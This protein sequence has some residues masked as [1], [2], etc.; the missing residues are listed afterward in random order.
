MAQPSYRHRV[1]YFRNDRQI[2]ITPDDRFALPAH[3]PSGCILEGRT[4]TMPLGEGLFDFCYAD[5]TRTQ[6]YAM[7]N[8]GGSYLLEPVS[9]PFED[10]LYAALFP[11]RS[12]KA[13]S[14]RA[15][16]KEYLNLLL[17]CC[18]ADYEP[19]VLGDLTAADRYA[20]WCKIN[21]CSP[22]TVHTEIIC[23]APT[24]ETRFSEKKEF[25]L[26]GAQ[27]TF[28]QRYELDQAE[29]KNALRQ[30]RSIQHV[31]LC[32]SLKEILRLE[33]MQLLE[34]NVQVRQCRRCRKYF[35]V[36]GNYPSL[37]CT[38][39]AEGSTQTCQQ[40]AAASTFH[41]KLKG[42]DGDNAWGVYSKYYKRYY[43]R[44][45][46]GALTAAEFK[47]WQENAARMR[48]RCLDGKMTLDEYRNWLD[49]YF[50]NP[51]I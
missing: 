46:R 40:L 18:D 45:K 15:L 21:D 12:R 19:E 51:S 8:C 27:Q 41:S 6:Q 13:A 22:E 44:I 24:N 47:Q 43:A 49:R 42:N 30:I 16:Q 10:T 1:V 34:E 39:T 4:I 2:Q 31:H 17:F 14:L 48:D 35:L 29:M 50:Q 36:K 23:T 3:L 9:V 26:N 33:F 38:R 20:L 7:Y 25:H 37:Y 32:S 5:F 28:A 11:D